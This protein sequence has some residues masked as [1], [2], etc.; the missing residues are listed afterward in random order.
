MV[1]TN[2][3][4]VIVNFR[5]VGIYC[6]IPGYTFGELT[7]IDRNYPIDSGSTIKEVQ[8][9]IERKYNEMHPNEKEFQIITDTYNDSQLTGFKYKYTRGK[10]LAVDSNPTGA[11]LDIDGIRTLKETEGLDDHDVIS[12]SPEV[13]V[14]QYYV[15]AIMEKEGN[16]RIIIARDTEQRDPRPPHSVAKLKDGLPLEVLKHY[17]FEVSAYNITWRLLTI[18]LNDGAAQ[19]RKQRRRPQRTSGRIV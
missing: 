16:N 11:E 7:S 3:S 12:S 10:P 1:Q 17:G 18:N 4:N 9:R 8:E 13:R 6:Y 14:W 2:E 19:L 15:S 5:V